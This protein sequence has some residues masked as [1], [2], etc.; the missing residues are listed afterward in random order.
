MSRGGKEK[1]APAISGDFIRQLRVSLGLTQQQFAELMEVG[2]VTVAG[3]EKS[4][5]DGTRSSSFPNFKVFAAILKQSIKHPD[6]VTPKK[7]MK[8]FK[9]AADHDLLPHYLRHLEDMEGEYLS[10]I[11]SGSLTGVLLALLFDSYLEGKGIPSPGEDLEG[12][13][14]KLLGI[15]E[16]ADMALLREVAAETGKTEGPRKSTKS[17]GKGVSTGRGKSAAAE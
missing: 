12:G 17:T 10:V 4:G 3:W 13:L 15:Q 7:L 16:E 2:N 6:F 8:Y 1:L 9:L 11:N 5:L 14:E